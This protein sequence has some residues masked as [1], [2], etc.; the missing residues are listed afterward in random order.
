MTPG[1]FTTNVTN[2]TNVPYPSTT[3]FFTSSDDDFGEELTGA[4][5]LANFD[6]AQIH[7]GRE[8]LGFGHNPVFG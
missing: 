5:N 2:V 8:A 7:A 4:S 6:L 1:F 3:S